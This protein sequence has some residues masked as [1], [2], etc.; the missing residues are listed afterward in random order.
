M[1]GKVY[2]AVEILDDKAIKQAQ[3]GLRDHIAL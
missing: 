2:K 1:K 3:V